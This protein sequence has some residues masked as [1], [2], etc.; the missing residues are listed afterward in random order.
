[1]K[2]NKKLTTGKYDDR[3]LTFISRYDIWASIGIFLVLAIHLVNYVFTNGSYYTSKFNFNRTESLYDHSQ[4]NINKNSFSGYIEDPDLYSLAGVRYLKGEDPTNINF[5]LQPLTKYLFGLSILLTGN[6]AYFQT[7]TGIILLLVLYKIGRSVFPIKTLALIPPLLLSLDLLFKEQLIIPFLDL[8]QTLTI[9]LFLLSLLSSVKNGSYVWPMF[10]LGVIA[11]SKS[12]LIGVSVFFCGFSFIILKN[13][14]TAADYIRSIWISV[15]TY[16]AGYSVYFSHHNAIDFLKLHVD[17]IRLYR[18]YV[19]EYPKGEIFRII[20]T[21]DWKRWFGDF[22]YAKTTQWTFLWP[23]GLLGT[24][25]SVL[26]LMKRMNDS[27]LLLSLWTTGYLVTISL[28][29]V[30]PRYL[31]PVL[32][33]FYLLLTYSLFSIFFR[34]YYAYRN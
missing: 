5:E 15:L 6:T 19:P 13:R 8:F 14:L 16:L 28:K 32:P 9:Q 22:G 34:K 26:S 7:G 21:G 11:L 30:F 2:S 12:F 33:E 29:L 10:W 18:S 20:I 17:I 31:L 27:I 25:L 3:I 24:I 4:Y 1:M 23:V